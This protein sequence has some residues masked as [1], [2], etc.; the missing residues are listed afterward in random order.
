MKKKGLIAFVI[1]LIAVVVVYYFAQQRKMIVPPKIVKVT[2]GSISEKAIA[3]GQ[4]LPERSIKVK[5]QVSGIVATLFHQEGDYIREGEALIQI[6]PI[7]S[8]ARYDELN[9]DVE[10]KKVIEQARKADL[11]VI[12][13]GYALGMI[14][15][16]NYNQAKEQYQTAI[17]ARQ[18]A[19][20]QLALAEKGK[21]TIG[22][23]QISS[24][25]NSPINGH[26]LER[27]VNEGDPVVAQS[28]AQAGDIL[29]TIADMQHLLFRGEVNEL[30]AV[31]LKEDMSAVLTVGALPDM[32]IKGKV[33]KIALQ[34]Q[35][36][37]NAANGSQVQQA[38]NSNTSKF[39][40]GFKIEIGD[41]Q[42]PANTHLKSGYSAT[43]E[44]VVQQNPK[45][46]L[47]PERVLIFKEGKPFVQ[48]PT[49]KPKLQA[50][51]IGI[52]DGIQVEI[53]A[54]LQLGQ[55]VLDQTEDKAAKD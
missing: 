21:V 10:A 44:I 48:L 12:K 46:L 1:V 52:S 11:Q 28:E 17:I 32:S 54:G 47:L 3:I 43:A 25:I 2:Q 7:P 35:Q 9:R 36:A 31:K 19:E 16:I 22:D 24:E 20:E 23:H 38:S 4:I 37:S 14:E 55:E 29:F 39:N 15:K 33:S 5:S 45:A 40:V 27:A 34:S 50:I 13:N 41:L 18:K 53:L 49:A 30:D 8:P 26:I 6:Q 42:I 51:K